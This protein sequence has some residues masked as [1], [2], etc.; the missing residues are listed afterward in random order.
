MYL[1]DGHWTRR[2]KLDSLSLLSV[3]KNTK[4]HAEGPSN[5]ICKSEAVVKAGR[6][7]YL[8]ER[9]GTIKKFGLWR[10]LFYHQHTKEKILSFKCRVF[11][12]K[13]AASSI[14]VDDGGLANWRPDA[15]VAAVI[16]AVVDRVAVNKSS[17]GRRNVV[18]ADP[19]RRYGRRCTLRNKNL[20]AQVR[21]RE[22]LSDGCKPLVRNWRVVVTATTAAQHQNFVRGKNLIFVTS[23]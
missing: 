15:A 16:V 14:T 2:K 23:R 10:R 21:Y 1:G 3:T 22:L 13:T 6:E 18:C 9:E 11:P 20:F 5:A 7:C 17:S 4:S 8:R 12:P 19:G